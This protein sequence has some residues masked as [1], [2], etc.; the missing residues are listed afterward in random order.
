MQ[1]DEIYFKIYKWMYKRLGLKGAELEIYALIYSFSSSGKPFTNSANW[2]GDLIGLKRWQ[3]TNILKILTEKNYI[4][5]E[6]SAKGYANSYT[7]NPDFVYTPEKTPTETI[8]A[9]ETPA[10]NST[11]NPQVNIIVEKF[12]EICTDLE[13]VNKISSTSSNEI[14]KLLKIGYT[15][16]DFEKCFQTVNLSRFLR[17]EK[18]KFKAQF[19]WII[20]HF[21]D[22]LSGKYTDTQPAFTD[23]EH[24][25]EDYEIFVNN[26]DA[27]ENLSKPKAK[28]EK[29]YMDEYEALWNNYDLPE[30]TH[31]QK[32]EPEFTDDEKQKFKLKMECE[33][34][35]CKTEQEEREM[36]ESFKVLSKPRYWEYFK[37]NYELQYTSN[38]QM[39]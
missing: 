27:W 7:V 22:V 14:E 18:S 28:T 20:K 30:K 31:T 5:K 1:D 8:P 11:D 15:E 32:D 16:S 6:N 38:A 37:Q 21:E 36:L 10:K 25:E 35:S 13:R 9:P 29:D 39:L 17:G 2:I 34:Y 26:Y 4:L 3:I 12:N 19:S 33:V 24:F 23:L